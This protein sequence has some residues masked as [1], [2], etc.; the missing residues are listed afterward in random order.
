[1][2]KQSLRNILS[3]IYLQSV[4]V[5]L[6]VT[7][8][9]VLTWEPP[10][11]KNKLELDPFLANRSE[12][13]H[14]F[15]GDFNGDGSS[16][17]IRCF[18]KSD[19][20]TINIVH[21]D[22]D[23]NITDHF[24]FPESKWYHSLYPGIFDIDDD[25][26]SELLYFSFRNDSVFLNAFNLARF[27]LIIEHFFFGEFERKGRSSA[28]VSYFSKFGDFDNN[29]NKEL[30]LRFDAGYG[31]RPR[32]I[33][34]IEFPSMK[35]TASPT[36]YMAISP[37]EFKDINA[38]GIP[39][40]FTR[41]YAPSNVLNYKQYSDTISYI[42]LLDYN[43]NFV[44]DPIPVSG[45]FSSIQT[46]P[47]EKN[48]KLFYAI[49][50]ARGKSSV[51]FRLMTL[52]TKGQILHEK[53]WTNI[54]NPENIASDLWNINKASYLFF[55]DIGAFKLHPMLT[56]LPD[57]LTPQ[58]NPYGQYVQPYD[59]D[60][61]QIPEWIMWNSQEKI[62]LHNE[63]STEDIS[64]QSPIRLKSPITIYPFYENRT[65]TK[66]MFCSGEGFF[67]FK[68]QTNKYYPLLYLIY[69][70]LFLFSSTF[71]FL[72]LNSQRHFI[73]KRIQT[74]RQ[75][76]ELQFNTVKNQLN[77]HFLFNALNSVALMINEGRNDEAFDF[78]IINSR[79]IQRVMDDA[80]EV[81]RSLKS[82]IQFTED[83]LKIQKH[84][85]KNRFDSHFSIHPE[86]NL[87][88]LVPKMCLHSYVENAIKHGFRNTNSGGLLTIE[89]KPI[90]HGVS[91]S[92]AD[93]GMGLK[94]ASAYHDSSGNGIQIMNE[95]YSLFEKY[96]GY[97]VNCS[98][99][100]RSEFSNKHSG[101]LVT[102]S[103]QRHYQLQKK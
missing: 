32:G 72:L 61:D 25:G 58:L 11:K 43:L 65:L 38:D 98:I 15:C 49:F 101:T 54:K 82:E 91:I 3:N 36:E 97:N 102:L 13:I 60:G 9:V 44:F 76:S 50:H 5:G 33:F 21:Y 55:K 99:S 6:I 93:N 92:V 22:E 87:E 94:A 2:P 83:Y 46:R 78:L 8:L 23:G 14:W 70:L 63:N 28:C 69:V 41:C 62:T 80:K 39:E 53:T 45:E 89:I 51:P 96:H 57:E 64:F 24:H 81:K 18:T 48:D 71:I 75:L 1:M 95:F 20:N 26:T 85:F 31:L 42:V 4:L 19:S 67:F 88:F 100:D 29:G 86:T 16:E 47:E 90:R 68:Y 77:P 17:R 56:E 37:L 7:L 52:N 10:I 84:R 27:E 12:N 59:L 66:F 40:I 35:I 30:F 74:E 34:K 73:E 103:I 79:M